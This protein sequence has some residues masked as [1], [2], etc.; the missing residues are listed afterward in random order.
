MDTR[1][2]PSDLPTLDDVLNR[3]TLPPVCLYNFYIVMRDRLHM[4]EILDFYLDVR[5]HELLWKRYIKSLHR[6]GMLTEED[7]TEGYQSNRLL[8]RLSHT[9]SEKTSPRMRPHH[10]Q[11]PTSAFSLRPPLQP[12]TTTTLD[13]EANFT[14]ESINTRPLPSRQ[15]LADSAQHILLKYIVP[16]AKK[17]LVHLP[18][19]MKQAIRDAL[20]GTEPRDDPLVYTEAKQYAFEYMQRQAYPK[21]LRLK[22]WGNVTLWQ[23]LGRLAVGLVALLAGLATFFSLIFLGY[24]QWG[25][26]FGALLPIWLGVYNVL[27]FLTGLDP[28]WVLLFNVS[29]TVTFHFNKIVQPRVKEI[30]WLRSLWLLAV[31]CLVSIVITIVFCAIPSRRL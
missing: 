29:E 12:P 8:S 7:L 21:F 10:L 6:S 9:S 31:V 23:Q 13:E 1:A 14:A 11:P 16:S 4:E 5:H 15:D 28:L 26:R 30:L 22:V 20:E 17:E 2:I 19:P 3:K 27:V 25:A 24:P 18:A